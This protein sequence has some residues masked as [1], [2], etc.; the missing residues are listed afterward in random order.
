MNR[1][2]REWFD[3]AERDFGSAQR[4]LEVTDRPHHSDVCFHAQQCI[5]KLMKTLLVMHLVRFD[6]IHDLHVLASLIAAKVNPNFRPDPKDL[7][8][9]NSGA[10]K[11]RYPGEQEAGLPEAIRSMD[12][13]RRVRS[14]ILPLLG[15]EEK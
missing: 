3:F 2:T 5:E 9:L 8:S 15:V 6:K 14:L 11:Y 4:Q 13:C 7:E 12:A 10:V 1:L